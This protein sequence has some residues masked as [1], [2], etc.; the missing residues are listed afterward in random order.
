MHRRHFLHQTTLLASASFLFQQKAMAS[1]LQ[2]ADFQVKMLRNNVGIFTERGGT[3]GFL[4]SKNGTIVI[5]A[6]FPDTSRHL[7]DELKKKEKASFLYLL[8]THHHGDHTA[9]NIAYKGLVEH[10][11]AQENSQA[12]QKR[13]AEANNTMDKQLLP[14][15]TFKEDWKLK[16]DDEKIKAAYFGPGHTNGDAVYHIENANIIHAGDLMFNKRHPFVDRSAGANIASWIK[17]LDGILKMAGKDTIIIFGHSLNPGEETGTIE[18]V[19]K[20]QDYL[21]KVLSFAEAEIKKGVSKEEFIRN[22]SIPGVTEWAGQ[23]IDRPL[24]AAYEELTGK[25]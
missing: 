12:N 4:L 16:L 18:N 8:N 20:F 7:I 17:D 24:T 1:I 9:G 21:G 14:D 6:Q 5:D 2:K 11:V 23:G 22:T 3:I 10:V 25:K 19:R 15:M 13:V